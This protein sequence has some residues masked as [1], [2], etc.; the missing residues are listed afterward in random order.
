MDA[1]NLCRNE[2][3]GLKKVLYPRAL[4]RISKVVN[5]VACTG[6]F[7]LLVLVIY[8]LELDAVLVIVDR[9]KFRNTGFGQF[10]TRTGTNSLI[11]NR[12]EQNPTQE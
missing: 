7:R 10:A 1:A 12:C 3:L 5:P 8:T 2:G 6:L 11:P 9:P 4:D